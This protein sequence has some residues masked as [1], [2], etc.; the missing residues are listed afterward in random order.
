MVWPL[1]N[2]K[3]HRSKMQDRGHNSTRANMIE[4]YKGIKPDVLVDEKFIALRK[5]KDATI[6][7]MLASEFLRR[8]DGKSWDFAEIW[9]CPGH[10]YSPVGVVI[11][12]EALRR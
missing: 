3:Q 4:I 9:F 7:L 5:G 11:N 6:S 2:E 10:G 12:K 1:T 8:D